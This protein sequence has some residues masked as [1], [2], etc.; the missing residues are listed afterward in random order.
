M[1]QAIAPFLLIF[2]IVGAL[3]N[4]FFG[5][6]IQN[7]GGPNKGELVSGWIGT[8]M[9][10][11]AFGVAI[12]LFLALRNDYGPHIVTLFDWFNVGDF[13]VPWEMQIDRLSS[14][15]LLVVTGVGS[16]IH[17]YAIGYMHGDKN[18][19]RFFTY[20]NLFMFFMLI[21]VTGSSYLVL[22]VGWEG[23]GLASFLLIGFWF[24]KNR[25]IDG[26]YEGVLNSN[27]SRKAFVAN[28]FGDLFMILAMS[29]MF[30]TFGSMQ[31]EEVFA[32]ATHG[33]EA[34]DKSL[35]LILTL[36]TL[37][38][39]LGAT[40]KSAQIPFF[41][42]LPDAMAGPTPVSALMHAA[43]MVTSGI[44]LLVRSNVLLEI[45][46]ES[47]YELFGLV[48][49]PELVAMT[50][51]I[52]ALYAG[53]IAMTQFDIKKV[54]AYSTVSQLGFMIAAV[55][56]GAYVAAMF[57]LVTH[58][59]FKAL[60]FMG[61]GSVIHGMEHGHHHL[62]DHGHGHD[63]HHDHGEAD[64][65]HVVAAAVHGHHDESSHDSAVVTH[66]AAAHDDHA[67]HHVE[68]DFD[69][70][71]MR[72]MGNIKKYMP[73][74][75]TVYIIGALAL[76][77]IV[78][79]AG[80]WSKD[81]ILAHASFNFNGGD[82]GWIFRV[83]TWLLTAAAICTAFYMGRQLKMVFFG[84]E[85]HE[86][87][88]HA[89]ESNRHMV[90]PLVVLAVLSLLGGILN[91]PYFS[92]A[93]ATA[94]LG[95]YAEPYESCGDG[96]IREC[97]SG[98]HGDSHGDDAHGD[99]DTHAADDSHSDDAHAE[100]AAHGDDHSEAHDYGINLALEHWLEPALQSFELTEEHIVHLPHTAQSVQWRVAIQS[101]IL[102]VLALCASFFFVYRGFN[103][104]SRKADDIDPLFTVPILSSF[105]TGMQRLPLDTLYM[106]VLRPIF[107]AFSWFCGII[108]D[109]DFY[110]DFVHEQLIRAP[111]LWFSG[112]VSKTLDRGLLDGGLVL[113]VGKLLRGFSGI[114]KN[115]QSGYVRNYA[116][117]LF[118][119]VVGLV[120]YFILG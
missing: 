90:A 94:S 48:T 15:M 91:F 57:H 59:F 52:T 3:I 86:A 67:D 87:T 50:G 13:H 97:F 104:E 111:Y 22:F 78:P 112:F 77:G 11:A 56:M 96:K 115:F 72:Y 43:T 26:V 17:I 88:Y 100:D 69:P 92:E 93:D 14:V 85:R 79:F 34:G 23:V 114:Y 31:F 98:G 41:V 60:L 42:W 119:G 68:D 35:P 99:A 70:Q 82:G 38:L 76:S 1:I 113:G 16:L 106:G 18:F 54:L 120:L 64:G 6:R 116:L 40:G 28:R 61:A 37:F 25:K 33:F 39:L 105:L 101:T 103:S 20:L 44:Y 7:T 5:R 74:T 29:L 89:S 27:A 2:P 81:E 80:F 63:D 110:H 49:T 24:D 30:W 9:S 118:L 65:H 19:A 4:G 109:W 8:L 83:V 12:A 53:L 108:L 45:V 58:A 102:A 71:D 51:A 21:L 55:G 117:G 84:H 47:G 107:N 36:I 75:T 73:W 95:H 62:H 46:R 66:T 32:A 10:F